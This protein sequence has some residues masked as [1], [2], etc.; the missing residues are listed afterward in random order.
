MAIIGLGKIAWKYD[1]LS[2]GMTGLTHLTAAKASGFFKNIFFCDTDTKAANEFAIATGNQVYNSIEDL[3]HSLDLI[4]ISTSTNRHLDSLQR[5]IVL[6]PKIIL[7][8]KPISYSKE[9]I[10]KIALLAEGTNIQFFVNF[11]RRVEPTILGLATQIT[12]GELGSNFD[13]IFTFSGTYIEQGFHAWDLADLLFRLDTKNGYAIRDSERLM[14]WH[15]QGLSA[16]FLSLRTEVSVFQF[17]VFGDEMHIK[18]TSGKGLT[19][20]KRTTSRD[21]AALHV[22]EL[23]FEKRAVSEGL[24]FVYKNLINQLEFGRSSLLS[25]HEASITGRSFTGIL[26]SK[27]EI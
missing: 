22:Y 27:N 20:S 5:A 2:K 6:S 4:V 25:L 24:D 13:A 1:F 18:Y 21:F 9:E 8:E 3:P 23:D 11:Q 26:E 16:F 15:Q 19:I 10:D 14:T 12:A 7:L 17:E